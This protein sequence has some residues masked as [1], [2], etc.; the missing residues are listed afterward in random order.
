MI[1]GV[2]GTGIG[3]LFYLIV[4]IFMPVREFYLKIRNRDDVKRWQII[5]K[6]YLLTIWIIIGMLITGWFLGWLIEVII[7]TNNVIPGSS[8]HVE[9]VIRISALL[10]TLFTL[11]IVY[12]NM[13]VL[14]FIFK[15]KKNK[16]Q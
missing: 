2:P 11:V 1:V 15:H 10:L 8:S 7:P 4:A 14:R 6:H 12:L 16:K 13:H 9:N 3:G 5:K